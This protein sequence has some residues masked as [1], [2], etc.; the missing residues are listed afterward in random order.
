MISTIFV[1][2]TIAVAISAAVTGLRITR[3]ND[4]QKEALSLEK[5]AAAN[6]NKLKVE[7]EALKKESIGYQK[8]LASEK[9]RVKSLSAKIETLENELD[10]M[11]ELPQTETAPTGDGDTVSTIISKPPT[12]PTPSAPQEKEALESLPAIDSDPGTGDEASPP[13]PAAQ[14]AVVPDTD[15]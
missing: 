9:K 10:K 11:S 13:A 7:I 5:T 1:V 4:R 14:P 6:L 2:I 15:P 8:Q 12:P 3:L